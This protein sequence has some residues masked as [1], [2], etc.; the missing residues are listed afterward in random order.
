M[1]YVPNSP[2]SYN[3]FHSGT[4]VTEASNLFLRD[5]KSDAKTISAMGKAIQQVTGIDHEP[6]FT[7]SIVSDKCEF[8]QFEEYVIVFRVSDRKSWKEIDASISNPV[9]HPP[10]YTTEEGTRKRADA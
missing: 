2:R 10:L 3:L 6:A 5:P 7:Q 8:H 9:S 4:R 1:F